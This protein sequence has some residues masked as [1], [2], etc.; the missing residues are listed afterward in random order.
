MSI[1]DELKSSLEHAVE[2]HQGD[3]KAARS[4]RYE[5]ADVKS[6]LNTLSVSQAEFANTLGTSL[7]TIKSWES[8]RR[9]PTGLAAKVLATIEDNPSFYEALSKH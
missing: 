9:N 3:K 7:D 8:R 5:I 1:F 2:I 6:I 4:T